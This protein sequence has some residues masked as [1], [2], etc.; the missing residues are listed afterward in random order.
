MLTCWVNM[1][2][3]PAMSAIHQATVAAGGVGALARLIDVSPQRLINWRERGVPAEY[4]PL[5]ERATG[6]LVRCEDL[7][8]DIEWAVLRNSVPPMQEA[9]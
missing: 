3:N 1:L 7:R 5:I 4:C 9:A 6:G 2:F 8:P